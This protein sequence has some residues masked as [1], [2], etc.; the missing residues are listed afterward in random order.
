MPLTQCTCCGSH[1]LEHTPILWPELIEAWGL[2]PHK[3]EYVDRQ[4]GYHCMFCGSNLRSMALAGAV[5]TYFGF[6]GVFGDFVG[7]RDRLRVLE[8]NEAGLLNQFFRWMPAHVLASF[9]TVDMQDLPYDDASFDL[10]V[11]SDTLEHVPDPVRGLAECRRV[12]A[13]GGATCFTVPIVVGRLTRSARTCRRGTMGARTIRST[14]C[15]PSMEV[16]CGNRSS[17][18]DSTNAGSL[19][20]SFPPALRLPPQNLGGIRRGDASQGSKA[21]GGRAVSRPLLHK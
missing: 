9:P 15:R 17:W 3:A 7:A 1:E 10:I 8:I 20:P 2:R 11:R 19:A 6:D 13:P 4:Q 21:E 18:P 5:M 12:M 14:W 16:T